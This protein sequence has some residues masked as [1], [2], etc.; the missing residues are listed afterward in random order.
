MPERE[1]PPTTA[2]VDPVHPNEVSDAGASAAATQPSRRH[3]LKQAGAAVASAGLASSAVAASAA[4]PRAAPSPDDG[5]VVPAEAPPV[6]PKGYNILFILTDQE[7][8]FDQWPFPVPGRERLRREGV[9]FVNHQIA[10]CVCSPSRSTVYTGQHIQ[11]TRVFDNCGIPWQ[12]DMSPDIRTIGDMMRDAGYYAAYL[13]KWHLSGKLHHNHTP[14]DTPTQEYNELIK[15]YG[16]DDYFGVGDLIGR[17][18]GGYTYDGLTT[19]VGRVVAAWAR[20]AA[21]QR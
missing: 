16:F 4:A 17:V 10:S 1:Q 5:Y 3:F 12:P 18:R 9:T 2:P 15:S 20:R 21:G 19:L 7:R 14:Y 8:H 13:G 11:H 6:P